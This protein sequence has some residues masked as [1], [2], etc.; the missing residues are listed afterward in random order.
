MNTPPT[1]APLEARFQLNYQDLR[2]KIKLATLH[3]DTRP[4][5][6]INPL[7]FM[8]FIFLPGYILWAPL[9]VPSLRAS[10]VA[11]WPGV[12]HLIVPQLVFA[13]T[14]LYMALFMFKL[15]H[16]QR[17]FSEPN[18]VTL[19]EYSAT[20]HTTNSAN[21]VQWPGIRRV[22]TT[23]DYLGFFTGAGECFIVPRRAFE[24]NEDWQRFVTFAREQW[25]RAQPTIA[26]IANA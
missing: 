1:A 18:R 6:A 14:L 7:V 9:L 20:R 5:N 24:S 23:D 26:P 21:V 17:K 10:G 25:Q 11:H 4:T 2:A 16:V 19:D 8:V 12:L 13:A 3:R 15:R 22:V